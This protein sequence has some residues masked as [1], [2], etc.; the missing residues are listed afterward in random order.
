MAAP[1]LFGYGFSI[2]F[3]ALFA[4]IYRVRL[5]VASAVSFRRTRV[6]VKDVMYIMVGILGGE[7]TILLLWSLISPLVWERQV[8]LGDEYGLT[9]VSS[10]RCVSDQSLVF[11]LTFFAFNLFILFYALVLCY[12]TRT[13]PSE[14]AESRWITACVVSYLQILLLAVPILA[15]VEGNN[16]IAF[17]GRAAIVFLMSMSAS[18]LV[19]GPKIYALHHT[20]G[21]DEEEI[22]TR[23]RVFDRMSAAVSQKGRDRDNAHVSGLYQNGIKHSKGSSGSGMAKNSWGMVGFE[24]SEL[25]AKSNSESA[26]FKTS[27]YSTS[28]KSIELLHKRSVSTSQI[29]PIEEGGNEQ[30]PSGKKLQSENPNSV[31]QAVSA[32]SVD[33]WV[34]AASDRK[35]R[36][37]GARSD[38]DAA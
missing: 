38:V 6:E 33:A 29:E 37:D 23:S 7:S 5:I 9:L 19:F 13:Y 14:F 12:L 34:D 36:L 30:A 10:G 32:S 3:S 22:V 17:F 18:L 35:T 25:M 28:D 20:R 21:Q 24:D 26:L 1:W 27:N 31:T 15:I 4:K 8:I 2:V 11:L 16:N